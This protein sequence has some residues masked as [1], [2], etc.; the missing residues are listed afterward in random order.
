MVMQT[1]SRF[2]SAV[3]ST[4]KEANETPVKKN[5]G[6]QTFMILPRASQNAACSHARVRGTVHAPVEGQPPHAHLDAQATSRRSAA[7]VL[8]CARLGHH[9]QQF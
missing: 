5:S 8:F 2:D 1:D 7:A 3:T 9:V 4:A 6:S